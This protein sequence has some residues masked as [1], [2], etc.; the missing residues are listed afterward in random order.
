[1]SAISPLDGRYK[2]NVSELNNF[3]SEQALMKF[4]LEVEVKYLI[5]LSEHRSLKKDL[6]LKKKEKKLLHSFYQNFDQ[7]EYNAVKRVEA[8]TKHD[9]NAVVE[10]LTQKLEKNVRCVP[11]P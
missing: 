6:S 8:K 1:M 2:K 4:R 11:K 3:F 9:V 7:K 5:A 10:Y